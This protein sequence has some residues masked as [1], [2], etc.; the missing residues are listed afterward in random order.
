MISSQNIKQG[1]LGGGA[2]IDLTLDSAF[3]QYNP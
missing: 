2:V 1:G 3:V